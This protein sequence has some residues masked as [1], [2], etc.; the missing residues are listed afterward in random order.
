M[1][2]VII[3]LRKKSYNT[4]VFS[5]IVIIVIIIIIIIILF[6]L[7][8]CSLLQTIL[9]FL[10]LGSDN[11]LKCWSPTK[12]QIPPQMKNEELLVLPINSNIDN[13]NHINNNNHPN[14][15]NI[16]NR[17]G[18]GALSGYNHSKT[19]D[20]I[21]ISTSVR[22]FDREGDLL[23]EGFNFDLMS[24]AATCMFLVLLM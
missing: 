21:S 7:A 20:L 14:Q 16:V 12:K 9:I 5:L 24:S 19:D 8:R 13:N 15:V 3:F 11:V 23:F 6:S 1:P 17:D 18:G 22:E 10:S 2:W 4:L